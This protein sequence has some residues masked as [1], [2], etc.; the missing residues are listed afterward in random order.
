MTRIVSIVFRTI[1]RNVFRFACLVATLLRPGH[2]DRSQRQGG[3]LP[4]FRDKLFW[5]YKYYFKQI[6]KPEEGRGIAE[7]FSA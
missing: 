5:I 1:L 2:F 7:H 4:R 6:E 3:T